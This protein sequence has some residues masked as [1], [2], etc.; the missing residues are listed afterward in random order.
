MTEPSRQRITIILFA[1]ILL[2]GLGWTMIS[3]VTGTPPTDR[4]LYTGF[5]L[6][7]TLTTVDT[8][9]YRLGRTRALPRLLSRTTFIALSI[10]FISCLLLPLFWIDEVDVPTKLM[11]VSLMTWLC[12]ANAIRGF[13]QFRAGWAARGPAALA[14]HYHEAQGT[15]EWDWVVEGLRIELTT[16]VPLM[17]RFTIPLA[18]VA[19]IGGF[20]VAPSLVY[21]YP[22]AA[23]LAWTFAISFLIAWF[24][25]LL[26]S[27]AAQALTLVR[28][29]R[30][31]GRPL[32]PMYADEALRPLRRKRKS[33]SKNR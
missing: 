23:P 25:Q 19:G 32:A 12:G 15:I 27:G 29:E 8:W 17:N 7:L 5:A 14:E 33:K 20:M 3:E 2:T 13:R 4:F 16:Y 31:A 21:S 30:A 11:A 28:L 1:S 10:W 6:A 9:L 24:F 26:G 18:V 22:V